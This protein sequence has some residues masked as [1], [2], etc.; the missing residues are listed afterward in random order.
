MRHNL[1]SA[2]ASPRFASLCIALHRNGHSGFSLLYKVR[3]MVDVNSLS[4]ESDS[5]RALLARCGKPPLRYTGSHKRTYQGNQV[6][7]DAVHHYTSIN[8]YNSTACIPCRQ[9]KVRCNL[10]SVDDPHEPP[11]Q[12]CRRESKACYFSTTRRK[13]KCND[14]DDEETVAGP[15]TDEVSNRKRRRTTSE[16]LP[17]APFPAL[18]VGTR[19]R[20]NVS[21]DDRDR[22]RTPGGSIASI[23]PL[24]RLEFHASPNKESLDEYDPAAG[25]GLTALLQ[26]RE[27]FNGHDAISLLCDAAIHTDMNHNRYKSTSVPRESSASNVSR[28]DHLRCNNDHTSSRISGKPVIT[29]VNRAHHGSQSGNNNHLPSVNKTSTMFSQEEMHIGVRAWCRSKFVRARRFSALEAI[30][31]VDYFYRYMCPLTP[32]TVPDY[33]NPS[34]HGKLLI[35]EPMLAV[36]ILAISS[37]YLQLEGPMALSRGYAVHQMLWLNLRGMIDEVIWGQERF[38]H[39]GS[40]HAPGS[41]DATAGRGKGCRTLGTIEALL[42]LTEWHPRVLHFS[43][44]PSADEWLAADG[45]LAL[46]EDPD[47]MMDEILAQDKAECD[48]PGANSSVSSWVEAV[49]RSDRMCWFLIANAQALAYEIGVFDKVAATSSYMALQGNV[50]AGHR[51]SENVR[52]LLFVYS[53]QTSGRL[54]LPSM[55]PDSHCCDLFKK[56]PVEHGNAVAAMSSTIDTTEI[57]KV[58]EHVELV[59]DVVVYFWTG[60]ARAMKRANCELFATRDQTRELISSGRYAKRIDDLMCD[61]GAWKQEFDACHISVSF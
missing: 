55:L 38:G 4:P 11:C 28:A 10:G 39:L 24:R 47:S 49:W 52:R 27:T 13:R 44:G 20:S 40:K 48:A 8:S 37:R 34:K 41:Y 45:I 22:P 2:L 58:A 36:T 46:P 9:R 54:T 30:A 56:S 57:Y 18:Q 35:E 26:T 21:Q 61:I 15:V 33:H 17:G 59:Q 3:K 43:T 60:I 50:P 23:S 25:N 16:I 31:Y 51:R 53:N 14:D 7:Y 42:F 12:R 32:V 6:N 19:R 1:T 5:P 29:T